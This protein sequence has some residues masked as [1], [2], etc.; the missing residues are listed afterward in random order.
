MESLNYSVAD[1]VFAA[2]PD[3]RRG[4]VLVHDV[5]NGASPPEL[6][7][8]LREE[9]AKARERLSM[10]TLTVEPRL[11]SWREAFR[12]LGYKPG[13][14]RP[15]IEALLRRVLRAQALPSINAL[16]DIGNIISL[17]HVLPVGGHAIDVL[18]GDIALR[19]ATG[20]EDFFPLGADEAEH[21]F[22]G[23]FIFTEREKVLTRRWIW[24]QANHTLTLPE[25]KAIEF[26][27]D[28]LPPATDEDMQAAAND[29]MEL[30][31][32]FC[33]G[34]CRFAVLDRSHP[35]LLLGEAAP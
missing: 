14:F 6:A 35:A 2:F 10:E 32:R 24:R 3:Y 1:E 33:G 30:V 21:P 16:V 28:R 11:A 7:R 22:P 12:R 15:S 23:E 29:I 5:R 9:E 26:N 19:P 8:L 17:R 34:R 18:S 31:A 25:T 13:D 4:V 27:I 20:S